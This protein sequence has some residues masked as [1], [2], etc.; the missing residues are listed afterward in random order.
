MLT[1]KNNNLIGQELILNFL[2]DK[3]FFVDYIFI[4]LQNLGLPNYVKS[5]KSPAFWLVKVVNYLPN[6]KKLIVSVKNYGSGNK[7]F[8]QHQILLASKLKEIETIF[9]KN[10][11]TEGLLFTLKGSIEPQIFKPKMKEIDVLQKGQIFEPDFSKIEPIVTYIHDTF[12]VPIKNIRFQFGCVSF[13]KYIPQLNKSL[14]IQIINYEIREEFD[15]LKNYFA[16][17]LKTKKIEVNLKIKLQDYSEVSETLAESTE[18]GRIN[19]D[20]I[21]SVKFEFVKSLTKKKIDIEI[22]KS[23]FTMDEYFDTLTDEKVKSSTFYKNEKDFLEDLLLITNAKHYK[24]FRFLSSKHAY[25]T[26]K[27]RY[28]IKPNFSCIFLI[29]GEKNYHVVWETLNTKE[30]TYIWHYVKDIGVVK[31]GLKKIEDIIG[32]IKVENKTAYINSSDENFQRIKHEYSN[33]VEGFVKWKGELES[34]L[35]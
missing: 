31:L 33:L 23:L 24:Q 25:N 6:D 10:I 8:P 15:A 2:E 9:F 18:I 35:N 3:A 21:D 1:I 13:E 16:N 19:K 14:E 4:D 22:D 5:F 17:V 20:L 32:T 29:E 7:V 34:C 11:D 28:I 30:A 27:I 26:M 12:S